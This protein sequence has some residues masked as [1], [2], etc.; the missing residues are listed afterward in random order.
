[1]T[2]LFQAV[3]HHLLLVVMGHIADVVVKKCVVYLKSSATTTCRKLGVSLWEGKETM[4]MVVAR[5]GREVSVIR[6]NMAPVAL[7]L[8]TVSMDATII[9]C[10]GCMLDFF[11]SLDKSPTRK[12]GSQNLFS[13]SP[14]QVEKR[15]HKASFSVLG[16]IN[17]FSMLRTLL[18]RLSGK[19][20]ECWVQSTQFLKKFSFWFDWLIWLWSLVFGCMY[21]CLGL[22]RN[23][24][25]LV[26]HVPS[27]AG[28]VESLALNFVMH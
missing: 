14:V 16:R 27:C 28:N 26:L 18:V 20:N 1:M 5:C 6:S 13:L 19:L 12:T 3:L 15:M 17:M 11:K 24:I 9:S 10:W 8:G 2:E 23:F 22:S 7:L 4:T 25:W 21:S